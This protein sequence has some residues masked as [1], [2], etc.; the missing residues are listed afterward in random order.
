MEHFSATDPEVSF[1]I[2]LLGLSDH[3]Q[4][5]HDYPDC[6]VDLG[7][8]D[9]L[10]VLSTVE[11]QIIDDIAEKLL[12]EDASSFVSLTLPDP[13]AALQ[14]LQDNQMGLSNATSF[15]Y[16]YNPWNGLQ[17]DSNS[18]SEALEREIED[19]IRDSLTAD[20]AIAS[21]SSPE[22]PAN[23]KL[24][25]VCGNPAGKHYLSVN[26]RACHIWANIPFSL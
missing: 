4:E 16:D 6:S 19:L 9:G 22:E 3:P 21:G 26:G 2:D 7:Q 17:P 11:Q 24:C 20:R 12:R 18:S 8:G 13:G 25:L 23:H 1:N 10:Q 15:I 14:N 5:R